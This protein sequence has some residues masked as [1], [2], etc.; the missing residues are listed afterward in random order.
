MI[1]VGN[2]VRN[3]EFVR[4][5]N[6]T[7]FC[8]APAKFGDRGVIF[9]KKA[10]KI[11][12]LCFFCGRPIFFSNFQYHYRNKCGGGHLFHSTAQIWLIFPDAARQTVE[13]PIGDPVFALF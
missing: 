11:A 4:K 13:P 1:W 9:E 10:K 2:A 5:T 6:D 12:H 7:S 8:Y 3:R